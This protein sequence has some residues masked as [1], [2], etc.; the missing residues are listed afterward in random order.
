MNAANVAFSSAVG[1]R[2]RGAER[3][4]LVAS[5]GTFGM[6]STPEA[7][8]QA[9]V[10]AVVEARKADEAVVFAAADGRIEYE[11][12]RLRIEADGDERDRLEALLSEYHVFKLEGPATRKADEGVVYLSAV[13]DPKHAADFVEALFREVYGA[14]LEYDLRV[15]HRD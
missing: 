3:R 9:I 6:V 1:R 14:G 10:E 2:P 4:L 7:R 15:G 5:D 13:T 8:R 11:D 12:R